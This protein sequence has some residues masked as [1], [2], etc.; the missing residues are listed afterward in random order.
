MACD[1]VGENVETGLKLIFVSLAQAAN[2]L[3]LPLTP[4]RLSR[5]R[6]GFD[7][8]FKGWIFYS[9]SGRPLSRKLK[10]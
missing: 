2:Y 7:V 8:P 6:K 5:S 3:S 4:L 10:G 9:L 1:C